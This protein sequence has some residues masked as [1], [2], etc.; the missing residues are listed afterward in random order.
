MNRKPRIEVLEERLREFESLVED[1]DRLERE[2]SES[3]EIAE[4]LM[5]ASADRALLLDRDGRI[6]SVNQPAAAGFGRSPEDLV[7][8]NAFELFPPDLADKRRAYHNQA[9]LKG[10]P[11][12]YEDQREGRWLETR[13]QPIRDSQG[14]VGR[15]AVLSRDIT[16]RIE[17]LEELQRHRDHLEEMVIERT[18]ELTMANEALVLQKAW[19]ESLVRNSSFGIVKV[20]MDGRIVGCN[21]SFERL[22]GFKEQE[23]VGRPIYE[24]LTCDRCRSEAEQLGRETMAGVASQRITERHRK[25]GTRVEVE[26][27]GVPV[28][29]EGRVIGAY[30][31]YRELSELRAAERALRES[32]ELFRIFAEDAPFGMS[33][34]NED[35]TFEYINPKFTHILG[36]TLKDIPDKETWFERVYPEPGDR[37]RARAIWT[38]DSLENFRVGEVK[39]RTF[40]IRCKNGRYKTIHF[41]AVM[42]RDRRQMMTYEDIT[43]RARAEE[44][45]RESEERYR[46]LYEES[47]R[48]EQLYRSLLQ[49][50]ADAVIVYDM[51]GAVQYASPAFTELFGWSLEEIQGKRVPFVPESEREKTQA[52]IQELIEHGT[53]CTGFETI[54]TNKQGRAIQVS[55]S[56][57]RYNDHEG[58]AAGMLVMLRDIS[59]QKKLEAQLSQANKME[60]IGT[61]A[62]GIA[63]DFNNI[64]Q[65]ISGYAQL[66]LMQKTS[67]HPDT[68]KL[69][70]I[71]RSA[72]RASELTERLLIFGRKVESRLRPVDLN[73]E[74]EQVCHLLKR[75][76]PKMIQ[77]QLDLAGD[78]SL[79][80]GDP[81]QLEQVAMNIA[82][83]ARDAMP[84]GGSLLFRTRN[85]SLGRDESR[86]HPGL[87]PGA[88]VLLEIS[89]TGHG[90]NTDI[91][92]HIYEPFFTTKGMGEGT[93]LG[94]AMVYG[95]VK[96]HGGAIACNSREGGGTVFT[97][98]FPVLRPEEV[99]RA[100]KA[101]EASPTGGKERILLVD[102]EESILD[103]GCDILTRYGYEP[104]PA[105]SGEEAL[106]IYRGDL[107][108]IALVILD[109]NMPGMGGRKCLQS[110]RDL[111]PGVKVVVAS[112][113]TSSDQSREALNLGASRFVPK[114]YRLKDLLKTVR[115]VI[116]GKA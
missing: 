16:D 15:V 109:L 71:E 99:S 2:L 14:T 58:K 104:V 100:E 39:P 77:I 55:I 83:N 93:G 87:H 44:A 101:E 20:G 107:D 3:R 27:F 97:V 40:R 112:G 115:E 24:T 18:A 105:R 65:A 7:G 110:L 32:E 67:D 52:L 94:L 13:L 56:A 36:Y 11:V 63:H 25:D 1:R 106:E 10:E 31:I 33:I 46:R 102:D 37:E 53:P 8:R 89:D 22:F 42:T 17:A 114:P 51:E 47:T 69:E 34:M 57:S 62:G 6:L 113:H 90:M 72:R 73:H 98:Y 96:N 21:E 9:V 29:V 35:M 111:S 68:R 95:I 61:L 19:A 91:L 30:G 76:I 78:L 5:N 28:T 75:T 108:R 26:V 54:R 41:R 80:N 70:A 64:L 43:D 84:E 66:L 103:I 79:I 4:A 116:D 23:L 49:S 86:L 92:E 38:S 59:E 85:A 45:L 82:V 88:Y 50:S 12:S 60:A 81:V 48:N 74:L